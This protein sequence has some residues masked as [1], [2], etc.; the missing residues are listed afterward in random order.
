MLSNQH[1]YYRTLRRTVV[2]F[3]TLFKHIQLVRY[4]KD[5][6]N[7]I[8]R[9]TVPLTY[10]GKEDFITRLYGNPDLHKQIQIL[11]PRMSFE[12]TNIAYDETRKTSSFNSNFSPNPNDRTSVNQ[13]YA[14]VPY[15]IDFEVDVYVRNVEDGTQIVEQIFPY[16]NPDY[17]LSMT[18]VDS[19]DIVRDVP[20]ILESVDYSNQYE[21]DTS[22]TVRVLIWTLR[23]K[24]KTWFFGPVNAGGKIILDAKGN[25]NSYPGSRGNSLSL[26]LNPGFGDYQF[27]E[28]V[29]QG[30]FLS[31]S[32]ATAEVSSWDPTS[33]T[34]VITCRTG[35]FNLTSNVIGTIT[36]ASH[37]PLSIEP[38]SSTM[39]T[40]EVTP[41]PPNANLETSFGFI[42]S[43]TEHI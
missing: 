37:R 39:V 31:E 25:I 40:I 22:T 13:Q 6:L 28:I 9:I 33:N 34:L 3:G 14:G 30:R 17:T 42:E 36:K 23:F 35:D 12:M 26:T 7:E 38:T 18:F 5:T 41:N 32:T 15:N 16:F 24:M 27:G 21:G 1:F 43:I 11:L 8:D 2:A 10:A 20:I 4:E 29:Y 19:M